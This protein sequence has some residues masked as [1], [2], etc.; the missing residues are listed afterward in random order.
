MHKALFSKIASLAIAG[1]VLVACGD[2]PLQGVGERSSEWIGP[3]AEEVRF[4][5]NSDS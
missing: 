1:A 5:S 2:Q 4:L 3:I